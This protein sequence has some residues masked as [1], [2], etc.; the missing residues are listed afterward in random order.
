MNTVVLRV[1]AA[2]VLFSVIMFPSGYW[3]RSGQ[4]LLG[5]RAET[6]V[7][8]LIALPKPLQARQRWLEAVGARV[9]A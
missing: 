9:A 4:S 2:A 6:P 1:V 7:L 3:L 5:R 8:Y